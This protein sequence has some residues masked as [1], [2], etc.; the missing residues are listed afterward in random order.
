MTGLLFKKAS[1]FYGFSMNWW[2]D[3][4]LLHLEASDRRILF[5]D[6]LIFIQNVFEGFKTFEKRL[7]I[8]LST[9]VENMLLSEA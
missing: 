4:S 5:I 8:A 9:V 3:Y 6:Q 7:R 1:L 2:S